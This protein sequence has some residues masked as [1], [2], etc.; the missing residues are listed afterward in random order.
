ML[1]IGFLGHRPHNKGKMTTL[2][3]ISQITPLTNEHN[4]GKF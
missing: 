4:T 3:M 2:C 1:T